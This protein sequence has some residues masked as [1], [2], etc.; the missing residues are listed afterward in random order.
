MFMKLRILSIILSLALITVFIASCNVVS[1]IDVRADTEIEAQGKNADSEFVSSMADF[2][3]L[4]LNKVA[5]KDENTFISAY[6][7]ISA[8]ALVANGADNNTKA[9]FEKVFGCDI[10]KLNSY[11]Y[12]FNEKLQS[13][14]KVEVDIANS[15]WVNEPKLS[16]YD[17]YLARVYAY[18]NS[19]VYRENFAT[20]DTLNKINKWCSDNTDGMIKEILKDLNPDAVMVLLNAIFFDAKWEKQYQSFNLTDGNFNN[21][22]GSKS[23]ASY[24]NSTEHNGFV[25]D[26]YTGAIKYYEGR[27]FAFAVLLPDEKTD[28]YD[29]AESIT[30]EKYLEIMNG[31]TNKYDFSLK[32]PKLEIE[33]EQEIKDTLMSMGIL[34]AF[35]GDADF[36]KIGKP[37]SGKIFISKVTHKTKLELNE[38]GTRAAA[39][40]S[41]EM[42]NTAFMPGEVID[43]VLDRPFVFYIIDT[44]TNVPIFSGIVNNLK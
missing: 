24:L 30:G 11:L 20:D 27:K 13:D 5:N 29:F 38:A 26:N 23:K 32:L 10:D 41:I 9:Q 28:V 43:V 15:V 21:Y 17:E 37:T 2:S 25:G 8:L 35:G 34:D 16:L 4:L 6:S 19:S 44:E 22:D 36:T 18:Y 33:F 12:S 7:V 39:V 3:S 40:T 14:E 31:A 42:R 1:P